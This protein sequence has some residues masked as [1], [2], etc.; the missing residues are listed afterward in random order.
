MSPSDAFRIGPGALRPGA[1]D[2]ASIAFP[3]SMTTSAAFAMT[4]IFTLLGVQ[5]AA[6]LSLGGK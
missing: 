6:L 1:R 5:F 3:K 4:F 2:G